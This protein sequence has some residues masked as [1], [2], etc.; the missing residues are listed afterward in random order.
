M[1]QCET[2]H[3]PDE[4]RRQLPDAAVRPVLPFQPGSGAGPGERGRPSAQRPRRDAGLVGEPGQRCPVV[5]VAA[6]QPD[7]LFGSQPL[8]RHGRLTP[9]SRPAD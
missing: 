7:L 4:I 2:L 8:T 3:R 9:A 1:A 5:E 6:Q